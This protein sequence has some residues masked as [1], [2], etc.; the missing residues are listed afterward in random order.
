MLV[1]SQ[2]QTMLMES[3]RGAVSASSPVSAFR[4]LRAD[5]GGEG[6]SREFWSQCAQMGWTGVLIA[7]AFG[8]I[9]FGV[10]GAG[11]IAREMA[12]QLAPSPFLS[13]AVLAASALRLGGSPA[14]KSEWLT[15]IAKG[16]AIIGVG[17]QESDVVASA[18]GHGWKLEGPADFVLDGH[19][20]DALLIAAREESGAPS[21]FLIDA[22][23]AGVTRDTRVLVDGRRVASVKF[24][25]AA[26]PAEARLSGGAGTLEQTTDI[27]RAVLA[28]SLCGVAEEAFR[29]TLD[30]LKERKQF[31]RKIGSFQA[32]QHRAAK[33][34]IEVENAWSASL[35]AME[36]IDG[37]ANT[38][39]LD[40]AVAKAKASDT[41][42]AATAEC[43][44]MHGGI[45]MTDEFDIGL[46]LKRARADAV[47]LGD[48]AFHADRVAT[49][50]GY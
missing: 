17:L 8:G 40:I 12:R 38:A 20:A 3:A 22:A 45:G 37:R 43:L 14:Q 33:M 24:A 2:D 5:A 1:L 35:K 7:E 48:G 36:A 29:R 18:A 15:R 9:D 26:L 44:Q 39:A 10:V 41:A 19:V 27:G 47:L 6:F 23:T 25:G 13:T 21:L 42:C 30:Y 28:A 16:E 32:L 11:L 46:Y 34:H 49:M 31:D 50:L 4:K